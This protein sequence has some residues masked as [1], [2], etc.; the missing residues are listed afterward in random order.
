MKKNNPGNGI[1]KYAPKA[2][3][4]KKSG[5][6]NKPT[7]KPTGKTTTTTSTTGGGKKATAGYVGKPTTTTANNSKKTTT[8]TTTTTTNKSN[9]STDPNRYFVGEKRGTSPTQEVTYG[10]YQK[11]RTNPAMATVKINK[12]DTA[13]INNLSRNYGANTVK[14]FVKKKV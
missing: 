2:P 7:G 4:T 6:T 8:T 3:A 10:Q 14:G 12:A 5:T 9:P 11:A 1:M 13:K